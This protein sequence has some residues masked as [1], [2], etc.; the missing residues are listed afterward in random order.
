[1]T[2][3]QE[4]FL[5]LRQLDTDSRDPSTW[6]KYEFSPKTVEELAHKYIHEELKKDS[7]SLER[8]LASS[9]PSISDAYRLN[10]QEP[11]E[12][13][14][15]TDMLRQ[16][17]TAVPLIL[18]RGVSSV[19]FDKMIE[20]A[21]ALADPEIQYYE[22]GFLSCSLLPEYASKISGIKQFK[23][24]CMP[25]TNVI[26]MGHIND[27]EEPNKQCRYECVVQ[28]GAQLQLIH[29]DSKY[30]YCIIKKTV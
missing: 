2:K 9:S 14:P 11:V 4:R 5:L 13:E 16:Y 29:E 27:E 22:K 19:P 24:F 21:T 6:W 30:Y 1:M 12:F 8:I 23:L 15:Y 20:S 10:E 18:Y 25:G 3:L 28:R 17:Q 7:L 26:Y